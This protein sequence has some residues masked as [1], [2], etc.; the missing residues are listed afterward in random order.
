LPRILL[1]LKTK[2]LAGTEIT[3]EVAAVEILEILYHRRICTGVAV[4]LELVEVCTLTR[5]ASQHPQIHMDLLL[6][7]P[8]ASHLNPMGCPHLIHMVPHPTRMML[9]PFNHMVRLHP[10]LTDP[11]LLLVPL[12]FMVL[13]NLNLFMALHEYLLVVHT[14]RRNLVVVRVVGVVEAKTTLK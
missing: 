13:Q 5:V 14:D 12:R 9:P 8:M 1:Q 3:T 11:L 4:M 2:E 10:N 7:S 6:H